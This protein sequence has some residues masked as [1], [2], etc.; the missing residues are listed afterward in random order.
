MTRDELDEVM[1]EGELLLATGF[2]AAL[3]GIGERFN[4]TFA[5]YDR[6]KV[7]ELLTEQGMTWD[8]A[9]EFFCFNI[10]GAWVGPKTP[11]FVTLCTEPTATQIASADAA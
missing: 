6:E 10:V 4:D 2:D 5:I 1:E 7:I 3:V 9:E 8:E 11:C